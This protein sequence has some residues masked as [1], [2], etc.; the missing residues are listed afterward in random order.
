MSLL[1]CVKHEKI[2]KKPSTKQV[3]NKFVKSQDHFIGGQQ[4][5]STSAA[6]FL[7][8]QMIRFQD[9]CS[10]HHAVTTAAM[11]QGGSRSMYSSQLA[12]FMSY[13]YTL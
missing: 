8:T 7:M 13:T 6:K 1:I 9:N 3:L 2:L 10:V 5:N 11:R 12:V 4:Q